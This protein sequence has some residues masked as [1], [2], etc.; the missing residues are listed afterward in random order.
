M[1]KAKKEIQGE[2]Y[3]H[4]SQEFVKIKPITFQNLIKVHDL[5]DDIKG[6]LTDFAIEFGTDKDIPLKNVVSFLEDYEW[7]DWSEN[8]KWL[9][10]QKFIKELGEE[11]YIL[12]TKFFDRKQE[13]MLISTDPKEMTLL[14]LSTGKSS[15]GS[16]ATDKE[17]SITRTEL[18]ELLD[19]FGK[20]E[21]A[22]FFLTA[23]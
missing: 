9:T 15:Y 22:E 1:A 23:H 12:K 19:G 11:S 17:N 10:T 16:V 18:W 3:A 20:E 7:N 21:F 8:F 2:R 6:L 5:C 13:V 4:G 14:D